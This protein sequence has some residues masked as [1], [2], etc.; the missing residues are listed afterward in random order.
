MSKALP[1]QPSLSR[2]AVVTGAAQRV[3]R[4][5]A[6]KLA[7]L[8]YDIGLHYYQ[9]EENAEKTAREIRALGRKAVLLCADLRDPQQIEQCFSEIDAIDLPLEVWV[10][11]AAELQSGNLLDMT[12]EE[13]DRVMNLNLRAVW[14]CSREAARRMQSG[15]IVNISDTG[16]DKVWTSL[17]AY[18]ISKKGVETLTRLLAKQLAPSIRVN[19]IAPGL[20]LPSANTNPEE[21]Q[22]LVKKTPL[23]Q[24]TSSDALADTLAFI[25]RTPYLTGE[26]IHV[27]G[28]YHLV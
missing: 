10:N 20:V 16:A 12:V 17:P 11:S 24:A 27:D 21:W 28:G 6:L 26:I 5:L 22:R 7:Q 4:V 2:L 23:Q 25:L 14:L 8:G 18:S 19:A 3:G 1:D 15:V 13:W 9:S